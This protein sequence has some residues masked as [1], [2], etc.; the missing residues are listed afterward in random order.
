MA[1]SPDT[2]LTTS[3]N[4]TVTSVLATFDRAGF[5]PTLFATD[6]GRVRCTLCGAESAPGDVHVEAVRRLEG[7]SDPDDMQAVVAATCPS[8]ARPGT[9]V[10]HYGPMAS[11]GDADVLKDLA[12]T[13]DGHPVAPM[14]Q[15]DKGIPPI[16]PTENG[17][18]G[19]ST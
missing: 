13:S 16:A 14:E 2:E 1:L 11:A 12:G 6:G 3:D 7:A 9:M 5:G 18:R 17:S 10:L 19:A 8:C 15:G 4:T